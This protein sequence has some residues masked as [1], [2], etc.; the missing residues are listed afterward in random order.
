ML[1][2]QTNSVLSTVFFAGNFVGF[3]AEDGSGYQY[4]ADKVLEID[5]FNPQIAGGLA[6]AYKKYAK[7]DEAHQALM[8]A[9][10]ERI[11]EVDGLS[12]DVFEIV[13][14]TLTVK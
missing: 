2:I 6:K 11:L 1:R 14:K 9:E 3:H 12:P 8:K 4:I 7:M 13:S 5:K 10:L